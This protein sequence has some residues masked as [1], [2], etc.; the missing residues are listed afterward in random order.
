MKFLIAGLIL[1]VCLTGLSVS[2][3]PVFSDNYE[4]AIKKNNALV[5][6]KTD[7]C[8][9]CKDLESDL[10]SMNLDDYVVCFVDA[11]AERD[12]SKNNSVS[13]FPTSIIFQKGREVSRKTGYSM[14]E[15]QKWINT[16]RRSK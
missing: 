4:E 15:Y 14:R 9:F 8:K 6:F 11:E 16:N 7:W 3:P 13:S 1:A 2:T 10:D 12:I 5:V